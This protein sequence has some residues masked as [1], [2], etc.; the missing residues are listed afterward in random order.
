MTE[1]KLPSLGEGV[2]SGTVAGILVSV[3]DEVE[4][5]QPLLELET[6]KSVVPVPAPQSGKIAAI[7]IKEGDEVKVGQAVLS[8]EGAGAK[9]TAQDDKSDDDK[10]DD[11][12]ASDVKATGE[13]QQGMATGMDEVEDEDAGKGKKI[14]PPSKLSESNGSPNGVAQSLPAVASSFRRLDSRRAQRAPFG[15][16]TRC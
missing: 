4:E 2:E 7:T 9:S 5:G 6:G 12:K 3:G 11:A 1:F 14:V 16:R 15:A 8:F 13:Q 10:A